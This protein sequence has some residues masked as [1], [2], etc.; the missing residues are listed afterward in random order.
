[1]NYRLIAIQIGDLLKSSTSVN[2]INRLAG[3]IFRFQRESFPNEAITSQRAQLIH[4]WVLS[5]AKQ[6]MNP[7][8][9]DQLLIR[10]CQGLASDE[11]RKEVDKALVGAG[12]SPE[13]VNRQDYTLFLAHD[14]H[15][16]VIKHCKNLFLQANYFHTVFE[17]CKSNNLHIK[18]QSQT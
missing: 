5:L 10:F 2:E 8:E 18:Q 4:D 7:D 11:N 6:A 3:A 17:A 1:M 13:A 12:V 9:R 16:E 15:P 14:F